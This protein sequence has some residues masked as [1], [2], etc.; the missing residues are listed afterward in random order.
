MMNQEA[1][2]PFI[3]DG[4]LVVRCS[5]SGCNDVNAFGIEVD[6]AASSAN[7]DSWRISF[8]PTADGR[9][10]VDNVECPKHRTA[11]AIDN[12]ASVQSDHAESLEQ[13]CKVADKIVNE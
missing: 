5:H 13:T 11:S 1:E 6:G 9:L 7:R 12:L 3:R 8:I 2:P 10:E 4:E